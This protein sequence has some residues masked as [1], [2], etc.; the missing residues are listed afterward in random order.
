MK[1]KKPKT[2]EERFPTVVA[3][4]TAD[5]AV[6]SLAHDAPMTEYIDTWMITYKKAGG[7]T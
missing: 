1:K 7:V 3:R 6:D 5:A 4:N 2:F